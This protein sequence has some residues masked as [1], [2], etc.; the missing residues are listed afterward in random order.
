MAKK[1]LAAA[2]ILT[3]GAALSAG[4]AANAAYISAG[5]NQIVSSHGGS[6]IVTF[7]SRSAADSSNLV[8][9]GTGETLFNNQSAPIGTTV[10]AGSVAA[11]SAVE[12]RLDNLSKSVSFVTGLAAD[13]Y[14]NVL[15]ALLSANPDGSITVSFEDLPQG[16]DF[17]YNDLVFSVYETP[18][19]AAGALLLTGL[20][21]F[22]FAGRKRKAAAA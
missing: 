2:A 7:K 19:P 16:G 1:F 4:G 5:T 6:L 8:F 10:N 13:N 20:A 15:H 17:D 14:D 18:I 11:G 21:G 3:A 12:F 9:L 22:G